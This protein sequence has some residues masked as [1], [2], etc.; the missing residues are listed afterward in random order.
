MRNSAR[1]NAKGANFDSVENSTP[2]EL[3][4]HSLSI[5]AN[6]I[7]HSWRFAM[8]S[9]VRQESGLFQAIR[10]LLAGIAQW[11]GYVPKEKFYYAQITREL[12]KVQ[13]EEVSRELTD[14]E[15]DWMWCLGTP[16]AI[17]GSIT[18]DPDW[19]IAH[20]IKTL[21]GNLEIRLDAY[22]RGSIYPGL[23]G[24]SLGR[25]PSHKVT[26]LTPV[27]WSAFVLAL[28]RLEELRL[29]RPRAKRWH[30]DDCLHARVRSELNAMAGGSDE[31]SR[32]AQ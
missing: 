12:T 14:L 32:P 17:S 18:H 8:L 6:Y 13:W 2:A 31:P 22:R 27:V 21:K 10:G 7:L 24:S 3:P 26:T 9:E 5:L 28:D 25:N 23:S 15:Y 16:I 20:K 1:M 4:P 11:F 30:P 29:S 19:R